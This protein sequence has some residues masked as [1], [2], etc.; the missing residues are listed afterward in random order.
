MFYCLKVLISAIYE[1]WVTDRRTDGPTDGRT[2]KAS[3]RVALRNLKQTMNQ[4]RS[5]R[6]MPGPIQRWIWSGW[7]GMGLRD[8]A[9]GMG[10]RDVVRGMGSGDSVN[11]RWLG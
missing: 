7:D 8:V 1:K 3:Y 2:H 10:L 6:R 11:N 4:H 9:K 5:A